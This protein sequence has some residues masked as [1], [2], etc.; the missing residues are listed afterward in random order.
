MIEK[1]VESYLKKKVE[2]TKKC[3]IFKFVSPGHAGVPD[4]IILCEGG[5]IYFVELKRPRAKP[6]PLQR[7]MFSIF[8]KYGFPVFVIDSK[9]SVDRFVKEVLLANE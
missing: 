5:K 3:C 8:E 1:E 9:S 4:R 7:Y 2:S 6:R